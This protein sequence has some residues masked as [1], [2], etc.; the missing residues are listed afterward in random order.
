MSKQNDQPGM[1]ALSRKLNTVAFGL[2]VILIGVLWLLPE[3][4]AREGQ[5]LLGAG[6]ILLG[7][8]VVRRFCG[9]G[10]NRLSIML[11]VIAIVVGLANTFTMELPY[12]PIVVIALG[13]LLIIKTLVAK[14][15]G[16]KR[17]KS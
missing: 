8:N 12:V 6:V 14:E 1:K 7:L 4:R 5:L 10:I 13:V 2:F 15:R 9:I 16:E 11:G 3:G 17:E